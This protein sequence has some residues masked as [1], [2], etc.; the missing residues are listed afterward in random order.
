MKVCV[1]GAG[2]IGLTTAYFLAKE[3]HSV[4][5]ID[6]NGLPGRETS[7]ANGGQLSYSYISPLATPATLLSLPHFLFGREAP[8]RFQ[9]R[10]DRSQWCWM[11]HFLRAC[12]PASYR[13]HLVELSSLAYLSRQM[14]QR[15]VQEEEIEFDYSRQG[16]LVIYRDRKSLQAAEKLMSFQK[17]LGAEQRLLDTAGCIEVEPA[18]SH[19]RDDI[20]GGVFTPSEEAGD[21]YKFCLA[22]DTVLRDRYGAQRLYHNRIGRLLTERDQVRSVVT[23]HLEV[24]AD[25]FVLAAG[26]GS[27]ELATRV[28]IRLPLYPLKGYSLTFPAARSRDTLEVSIT[29][30]RNK[31]VYARL[32]DQIRVAAMVDIGAGDAAIDSGRTDMLRRQVQSSFPAFGSLDSAEEWAGERPATAQGKPIISRTKYNN[33]YVNAGHGSLGFTLACGSAKILSELIQGR[34]TSIDASPFQ[35]EAVR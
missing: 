10:A 6:R 27:R 5:I 9:L 26:L 32:G 14:V 18:L 4:T 21:C 29:D 16:K 31:I 24:E 7:Y 19:M 25:M 3:G 15:L 1:L 23:N 30:S 34:P 22:L 2:V 28:G 8:L 13:R 33:L 35:I 20:Q 12:W 17:E 11:L